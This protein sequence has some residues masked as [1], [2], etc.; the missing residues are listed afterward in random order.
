MVGADGVLEAIVEANDATP[1]QRGIG[2]C[3]SGVMAVDGRRLFGWL[4]RLGNA[5]AKD[6]YYLTDIVAAGAR[7]RLP[8]GVVEGAEQSCWA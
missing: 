8:C 5:N 7:R 3:N 6:E 2:L 1:E 4:D